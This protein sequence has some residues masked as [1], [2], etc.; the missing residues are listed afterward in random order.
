MSA[1]LSA[2]SAP[3]PR[4]GWAASSA[5]V[6]NDKVVRQFSIMAVVWGVVSM[7]VGVLLA[8]TAGEST[9]TKLVSGLFTGILATGTV[10]LMMGIAVGIYRQLAGD[11]TG[12]VARAFD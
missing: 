9:A 10:L 1:V 8:V 2:A 6:Y 4:K 7:L 3:L 12:E 5:T 11:G